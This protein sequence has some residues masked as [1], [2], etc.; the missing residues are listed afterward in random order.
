MLAVSLFISSPKY[1]Q[2]RA[3]LSSVVVNALSEV[4]LSGR[5][6]ISKTSFSEWKVHVLDPVDSSGITVCN[7][8][9]GGTQAVI[10]Q[11]NSIVEA[12]STVAE[13]C[14][15]IELKMA[16]HRY[17]HSASF[18]DFEDVRSTWFQFFGHNSCNLSYYG[19]YKRDFCP[20][21]QHEKDSDEQ[22]FPLH[23]NFG[24]SDQSCITTVIARHSKDSSFLE[25]ATEGGEETIRELVDSTQL[26]FDF[27]NNACEGTVD[28]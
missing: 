26:D 17:V 7:F 14:S 1:P 5:F 16:Q 3:L 21:E 15:R 11:K 28:R 24:A 12:V 9:E 2:H 25:V 13:L 8:Y 6:R 22:R 20:L 10:F 27:Y 23:T 4:G 19:K 18:S